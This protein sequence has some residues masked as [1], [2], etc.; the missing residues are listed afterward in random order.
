M[1]SK[2][3]TS[4][5]QILA[6]Y[7]DVF[8]GIGCLP[9]PPYHIQVNPS[10]TPMQTSCQPIP[11]HLKESFKKE[12]DK[13]L[14][15]GVLKSVNQATPWINNFLLVEGKDKCGNLKLRICLDPTNLNKAIVCEA[16]HFKTPEDIAHLLASACVITVCDCRKCYWHQQLDKASSFLTMFNTE[17]GRLQYTV[18]P[19]GATVASDVF[20]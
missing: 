3:I 16:C 4:K 20:Q 2:L 9:D 7:S 17:L 5:K 10:V 11:V 12:I 19:F 1:V 14:Q 6:N 18:M 8:D 15:A 13:I